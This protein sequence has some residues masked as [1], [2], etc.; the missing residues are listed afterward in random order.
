MMDKLL[1]TP[2]EAARAIG[3]GRS[4]LYELLRA[5][6]IESVRIGGSR[7]VPVAA[8]HEYVAQL[9]AESTQRHARRLTRRALLLVS[10][11]EHQHGKATRAR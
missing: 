1:L 9:R 2:D 10:C 4:K 6:A 8:M 3:L 7:R 5:G 11:K